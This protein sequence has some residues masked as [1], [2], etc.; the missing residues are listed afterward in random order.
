MK[1]ARELLSDVLEML[2]WLVGVLTLL[3]VLFGKS[4]V[5]FFGMD[6]V[7]NIGSLAAQFGNAVLVGII[8]AGLVAW[9]IMRRAG[10]GN[11]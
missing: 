9:L 2:L 1:M 3:Q 10:S 6:V 5:D 7:A 11:P 8:A 4:F